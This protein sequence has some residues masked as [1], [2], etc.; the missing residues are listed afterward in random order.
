MA[1][2]MAFTQLSSAIYGF[3]EIEFQGVIGGDTRTVLYLPS[4]LLN[5]NI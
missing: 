2:D 3:S 4:I 1:I 5:C